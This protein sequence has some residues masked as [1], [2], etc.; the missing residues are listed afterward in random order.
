[1]AQW[2]RSG[3]PGTQMSYITSRRSADSKACAELLFTYPDKKRA[4]PRNKK[5]RYR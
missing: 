4:E 1:M 2:A 3:S 5:P